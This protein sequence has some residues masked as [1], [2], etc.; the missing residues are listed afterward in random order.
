MPKLLKHYILQIRARN[1]S[2]VEGILW[3]PSEQ[4][5]TASNKISD[6]MAIA[7]RIDPTCFPF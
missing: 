3:K 4:D 2:C 5:K 6:A 7:I 1:K